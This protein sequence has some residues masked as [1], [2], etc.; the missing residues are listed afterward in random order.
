MKFGEPV[1]ITLRPVT[2]IFIGNGDTIKPL[3]YIVDG[4]VIHV[5][6]SDRF[7]RGLSEGERQSYLNWIEPI[8]DRLADFDARINQADRNFK[9]KGQLRRQRRQVESE[10]SCEVFIRNRLGADPVHFVQSRDCIAYSVRWG[11]RPDYNGF[12]LHIKDAQCRPYIPGTEIK[13][14]LRTSLLYFLLSDEADGKENYN[15]LKERLSDFHSVYRSGASPKRKIQKLRSI[16]PETER[17][18]LRGGKDDAKFDFFKLVQV[19]DSTTLPN[20]ALKI[21]LTQSIGTGRYTKTWV[22]TIAPD[23]ELAFELAVAEDLAAEHGWA[24]KKLGLKELTEWL[25]ISRLLRACFLRSAGI[26]QHEASY[27]SDVPSIRKQVSDLQR[28]NQPDA[29]LLRLGAGQGFLGTT[30]DLHVKVKDGNLY[31][32]AIREGVSFQRRW[33]TQT[34]N[35]PKTR[36]AIT[37]V[38]GKPVHL[39]GWVRLSRSSKMDSVSEEELSRMIG[40]L[41]GKFR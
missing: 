9:L 12:K 24:L 14:A 26:L 31:D 23:Q 28:Q 30:V 3:S 17:E 10:L 16:A 15:S 36:R 11:T 6:D 8:L 40:K 35:F 13:G 5:L 34:G 29:P 37:D 22:E 41:K 18:L 27:F 4:P 1:P 19:S 21:E 25:D 33:R 38:R 32:E 7:F 39:L 20:D 2:P